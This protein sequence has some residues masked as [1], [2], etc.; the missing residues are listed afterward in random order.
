MTSVRLPVAA[1]F[2]NRVGKPFEVEA[3][4]RRLALKLDGFQELPSAGREGGS[5]RLEFVGPFDP[6]LAQGI[7]PFRIA[8]D[9]F[10]IFVVPIARDPRG[11]RYEAIFY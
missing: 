1:D 8:D 3:S 11:I 9:R 7:F 10:E 6:V 2:V 5:F 4:G